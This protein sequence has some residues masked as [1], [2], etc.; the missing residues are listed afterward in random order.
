LPPLCLFLT[1]DYRI[2]RLRSLTDLANVIRHAPPNVASTHST[3]SQRAPIKS[4]TAKQSKCRALNNLDAAAL[5]EQAAS[6]ADATETYRR[7]LFESSK[8]PHDCSS[9][10]KGTLDWQVEAYPRQSGLMSL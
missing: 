6:L 5:N 9:L 2:G 3:V 1:C 8:H 4:L 7:F 10:P